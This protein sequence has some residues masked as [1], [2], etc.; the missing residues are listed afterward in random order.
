MPYLDISLT[1]PSNALFSHNYTPFLYTC[2]Q[3]LQQI[4]KQHLS[5]AGRVAAFKIF[6]LP[7]L[8]YLYSH[9]DRHYRTFFKSIQQML[10][11]YI[12]SNKKPRCPY[13]L[14]S[15]SK[16]RHGAPRHKTI[17]QRLYQTKLITGLLLQWVSKTYRTDLHAQRGS[18][19]NSPSQWAI[20]NLPQH[21]TI[22]K[23]L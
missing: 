16:R 3:D 14:L 23:L 7:K 21:N 9:T 1:T 12:W 5:W 8:L 20:P 22:Q 6:T 13:L 11:S 18:K 17:I 15:D 10:R 4:N 19:H 2:R